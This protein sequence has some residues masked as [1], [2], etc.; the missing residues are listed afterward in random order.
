V[1]FARTCADRPLRDD[2]DDEESRK[3]AR[4]ILNDLFPPS[5]ELTRSLLILSELIRGICLCFDFDINN[6]PE[7]RDWDECLEEYHKALPV[8]RDPNHVFK[9]NNLKGLEFLLQRFCLF[10]LEPFEG[11]AIPGYLRYGI[12]PVDTRVGDI[13]IP[14][15]LGGPNCKSI[16]W[17]CV[18]LL[19]ARPVSDN[20]ER[21]GGPKGRI[22][23]PALS[24]SGYLGDLR[25]DNTYLMQL[26]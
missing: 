14:V 11:E 4:Q 6:P 16:V 5:I 20:Q 23:G 26:V 18:T 13:M 19:V 15:W 9:L 12:G 17:E 7:H 1:V 24:N 22:V 8:P 21:L 25:Q 3:R 10:A 2:D